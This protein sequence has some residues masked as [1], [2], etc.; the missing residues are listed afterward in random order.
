MENF[1]R[2]VILIE[3][4]PPTRNYLV[5]VNGILIEIGYNTQ[6]KRVVTALPKSYLDQLQPG[7]VHMAQLRLLND[8]S[9]IISEIVAGTNSKLVYRQDEFVSH[10]LVPY[11]G[12][13][14]KTGYDCQANRLVAFSAEA[15]ERPAKPPPEERFE[16]WESGDELCE[17]VREQIRMGKSRFIWRYSDTLKFHEVSIACEAVRVGYSSVKGR[18][19]RYED[20]DDSD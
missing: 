8:E 7:M 9:G 20:P 13:R 4:K 16:P 17:L 15:R 19:Y 6:T 5:A 11:P 18:L 1:E 3:R 2:Q 14:L 12:F 10:Y